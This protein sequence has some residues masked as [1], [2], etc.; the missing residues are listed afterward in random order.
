MKKVRKI[1]SLIIL[2][3]G[4]INFAKAEYIKILDGHYNF[5]GGKPILAYSNIIYT[6][7]N[8]SRYSR[9]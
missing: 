1:L 5:I 6:G 2:C 4:G 7:I 8:D 3:V 9:S